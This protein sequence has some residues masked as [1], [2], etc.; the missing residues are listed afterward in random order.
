MKNTA[1]SIVED[2]NRLAVHIGMLLDEEIAVS[3]SPKGAQKLTWEEALEVQLDP[4]PDIVVVDFRELVLQSPTLRNRVLSH[5]CHTGSELWVIDP[6]ADFNVGT[7]GKLAIN[8]LPRIR[9]V[10]ASIRNSSPCLLELLGLESRAKGAVCLRFGCG[11][12][13]EHPNQGAALE[14]FFT[15]DVASIYVGDDILRLITIGD[16]PSCFLQEIGTIWVQSA[17]E[18]LITVEMHLTPL[19]K[20]PQTVEFNGNVFDAAGE[21]SISTRACVVPGLNPLQISF[22]GLLTSLTD[23]GIADDPRKV[24]MRLLRGEIRLLA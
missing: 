8:S 4:L 16:K 3:C 10:V 15:D 18:H 6:D 7:L 21:V 12:V 14:L 17:R 9:Q 1:I 22:H 20:R 23:L 24:S 5:L 19:V 11:Q 13:R 2:T